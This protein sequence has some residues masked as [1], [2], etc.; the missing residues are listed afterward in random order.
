MDD[1]PAFARDGGFT[2]DGRDQEIDEL[3]RI[4]RS[5]KQVI[6]EMEDAER[7][8]TGIGSLKVRFN[9]VF[10]YYIEISKSN[11]HAVPSDYQRKQTIAGGERFITPALKDYEEKVLGADER[12]LER[13]L[14]VITV[15]R[16]AVA[17]ESPRIQAS[18]RALAALDVLASLAEVASNN[19]YIKPHVHD[20]DEM[21]VIDSRHPVVE[22][23][24]TPGSGAAGADG[25]VP[26][27]ITLNGT[28]SQ[29][30]IL[31]GPNM[32]GKSTYLRQAA[33]LCL[34]AQAGSFVPAR[35]AKLPVVDRIFA[36]VGASDNIARGQSTFMVEMQ[37]TAHI[38][39]AATTRSL[40]VLDEIGRGTATFDGLSIAWAVAEYLATHARVRPKTLFATHYHELTDLADATPGVVNFHVAAREWKDDIIFLRKIVPGRSDRSYGI[41]VARLAG[42]PPTVIARAREILRALERDELARGGRPSLSGTPTDPRRQ[43]ALFQTA[44]AVDD[45]LREKLASLDVDDMTPVEALTLLSELKK[46]L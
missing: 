42:L 1:P 5:G 10:G 34:M 30:M 6:A 21:I 33:L 44:D 41:Q 19:N 32:G 43:L 4:S 14:E 25:F 28:T 3:R 45:P 2:R 13:E 40:V 37:E 36:R 8:R 23:H 24:A 39:H 38:L 35:E 18:A 17:A 16:A 26:N 46:E 11:L 22:R 20:A 9:R 31:T 29:L 7:T 27:D 15:L 12:I